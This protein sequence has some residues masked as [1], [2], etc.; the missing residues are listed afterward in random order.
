MVRWRGRRRFGVPEPRQR[1]DLSRRTMAERSRAGM[2]DDELIAT[3]IEQH[4]RKPGPD[5]ALLIG[6]G[7]SVWVV[8]SSWLQYD[9]D[10]SCVAH[11]YDI[12]VIAVRA[13]LAHYRKYKTILDA[14]LLLEAASWPA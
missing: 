2:T 12:P 11:A 9:G 5:D 14:R 10:V 6:S 8:I 13:A 3:Y 7:V 1:S 4:P